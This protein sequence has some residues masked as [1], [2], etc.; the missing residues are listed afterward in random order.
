MRGTFNGLIFF[1]RKDRWERKMM[2]TVLIDVLWCIALC[3]SS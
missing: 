3:I 2:S 1:Y